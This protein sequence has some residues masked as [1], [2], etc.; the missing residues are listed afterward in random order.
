MDKTC[1]G[2]DLSGRKEDA[3]KMDPSTLPGL[4]GL[5]VRGLAG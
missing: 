2:Q 3:S 1:S 5:F 4:K